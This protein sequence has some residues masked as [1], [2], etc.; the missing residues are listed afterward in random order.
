MKLHLMLACVVLVFGAACASRGRQ[1]GASHS[2][3]ASY[4]R[5]DMDLAVLPVVDLEN[6][7]VDQALNYWSIQSRT[8]HPRHA[9][10]P[11]VPTFPPPPKKEVSGAVATNPGAQT[12][13]MDHLSKVTVRR[14]DITSKR[15]L[16]EICR[17]ANLTWTITGRTI[18][19]KPSDTPPGES[20]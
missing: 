11:Y 7:R 1:E 5:A 9:K 6:V 4:I 14:R 15:L 17:Q 13:G 20:K 18:I 10:F 12:T 3:R 2:P 8:Y 19:I 16:D